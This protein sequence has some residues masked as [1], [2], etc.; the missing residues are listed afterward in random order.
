MRVEGN[1]SVVYKNKV[2]VAP[3]VTLLYLDNCPR[4]RKKT[5]IINN[6]KIVR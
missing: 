1:D 2:G 4:L 6:S 3:K 5:Y